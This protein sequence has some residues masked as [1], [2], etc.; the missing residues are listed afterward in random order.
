MTYEEA[1]KG[2]QLDLPEFLEWIADRLVNVY[3]ESPNVDFVHA[4]R[5]FVDKLRQAKADSLAEVK[6]ESEA[7]MLLTE[8]C[9]WIDSYPVAHSKYMLSGEE[10]SAVPGLKEWWT[11]RK[12]KTEREEKL[13]KVAA[14]LSLD[15]K[16]VN[17]AFL[18]VAERV[19]QA[20]NL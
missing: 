16:T 13:E 9:K 19:L 3:K 4:C 12:H 1:V 5:N 8:V 20:L 10:A 6:L 18:K 2:I 15:G 11:A 7:V 14:A 17:D